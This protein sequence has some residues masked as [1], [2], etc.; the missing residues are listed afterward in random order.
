MF[1][2][3]LPDDNHYLVHIHPY[4]QRHYIKRFE[5]DYPGR[6]WQVT[7]NSIRE[8]LRRVR[9]LAP[10]SQVDELRHAGTCWLF[11]YDFTV[12]LS[13]VSPKSSGNRCLV[14]FDSSSHQLT[15]LLLYGKSDLP[16]KGAETEYLFQTM[17]TVYADF[18]KHFEDS[19]I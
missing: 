6:R 3:P 17:R 9:A 8:D 10:T 1:T 7:L 16:R 14:F 18:W 12:A 4:A 2:N 15:I 5:K 13:K 19:E 11:K